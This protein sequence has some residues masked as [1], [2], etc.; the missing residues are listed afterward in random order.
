[1]DDLPPLFTPQRTVSGFIESSSRLS[2]ALNLSS[3]IPLNIVTVSL[4]H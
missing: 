2:N 1:M 3:E 4:L